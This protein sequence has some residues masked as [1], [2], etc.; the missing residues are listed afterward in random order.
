MC[1]V[2]VVLLQVLGCDAKRQESPEGARLQP[3][4]LMLNWYPEAEHGGFYAAKVL[5]IFERYGLDV[6]I[7]AGGPNAPV[8]QE[9]V[10]GR[11]QFAIGNADDVLLFRNEGVPVVALM[12]PLQNTPR[13]VLVRADSGATQLSELSGFVL[14]ANVGRPFL[15]FLRAAGL[16]E[17]VQVVPYGGSVAKLVSDDKTAIQAYSFSEP[18][19]AREQ[20][21]EVRGLML[22]DVGFNPYA[23]C[24]LADEGYVSSHSDVVA[25]MVV[26]CREGWQQYLESPEKTNAAILKENSQGLT[27]DALAFGVSELKPLCLP[28]GMSA[29]HV[30]QMSADRWE[31]LVGQLVQLQLIDAKKVHASDVFNAEFLERSG[32]Q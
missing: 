13:C 17:G 24:L 3:V 21:I 6:T 20:G 32:N 12:A 15:D 22:S 16:L 7:R 29:D 27:A 14:Q 10:T 28:E 11:V 25:R 18:F 4:T 9:L 5:G 23:S 31:Q 8:A 2:F 30:G 26:A 19:M 1:T